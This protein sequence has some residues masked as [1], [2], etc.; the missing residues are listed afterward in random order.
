MFKKFIE[1]THG[2]LKMELIAVLE[3][4]HYFNMILIFCYTWGIGGNYF[5]H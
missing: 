4:E 2:I 5:N 1:F 3:I